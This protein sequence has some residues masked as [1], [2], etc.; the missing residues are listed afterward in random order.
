MPTSYV[1]QVHTQDCGK[2]VH[3]ALGVHTGEL[4]LCRKSVT[5][6]RN[7]TMQIIVMQLEEIPKQSRGYD[8]HPIHWQNLWP[9]W[10]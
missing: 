7:L 4:S 9:V 6:V 1:R 5:Y 3:D 2:L 8:A 10:P